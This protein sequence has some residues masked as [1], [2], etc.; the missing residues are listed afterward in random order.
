MYK[1]EFAHIIECEGK[2][3]DEIQAVIGQVRQLIADL[4]GRI[5][6]EDVWGQKDLTYEIKKQNHG[7]YMFTIL[8]MDGEKMVEFEKRLKLVDGTLR[9]M[10]INLDREPGYSDEFDLA[11]LKP[12]KEVEEV[13]EETTKK[14]KKIAKKT[15][16][17]DEV[18]EKEEV[19]KET[20]KKK[21]AVK[22]DSATTQEETPQKDEVKEVAKEKSEVKKS[23][24]KEKKTEKT[25]EEIDKLID[26]KLN[27][28]L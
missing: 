7:F 11:T 16:V 1:Y 18:A 24:K 8:T 21:P 26:E 13:E 28:L 2:K 23:E 14:T 22:K 5:Q 20:T 10:I 9:Y 19:K 3:E 4:G 6:K 15:V 27:E 12:T 25:Q 17:K